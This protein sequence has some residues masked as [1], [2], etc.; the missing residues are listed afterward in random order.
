MTVTN[1][2]IP[3]YVDHAFPLA[4]YRQEQRGT[5]NGRSCSDKHTKHFGTSDRIRGSSPS[6][7]N[8]RRF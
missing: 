3:Y 1:V 6:V 5:Y 7:T 2:L 4:E 8:S